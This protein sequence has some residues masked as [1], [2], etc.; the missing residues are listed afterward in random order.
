MALSV[1]VSPMKK[2]FLRLV[3]RCGKV[4]T[5]DEGVKCANCC[6]YHAIEL[7]PKS[8][9]GSRGVLLALTRLTES[10]RILP[11][12]PKEQHYDGDTKSTS[13]AMR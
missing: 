4:L 2:P 8:P 9:V 1:W 10:V 6:V 12:D 3:L 7:L 13:E 11:Y 5:R